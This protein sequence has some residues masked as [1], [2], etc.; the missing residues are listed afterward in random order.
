MIVMRT[1]LTWWIYW[2][3]LGALLGALIGTAHFLTAR[4]VT[5]ITR[6]YQFPESFYEEEGFI[7]R[8]LVDPEWLPRIQD[9]VIDREHGYCWRSD[10]LRWRLSWLS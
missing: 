3:L 5:S 7:E 8:I 6:T 9:Y 2:T 4:E 1:L 10:A